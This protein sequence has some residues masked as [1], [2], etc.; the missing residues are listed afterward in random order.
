MFA[1]RS[2]KRHGGC[3]RPWGIARSLAPPRGHNSKAGP[4]SRSVPRSLG[5][6]ARITQPPRRS[7]SA[8]PVPPCTQ[9]RAGA[10]RPVRASR[11]R[12]PAPSSSLPGPA[13]E[14]P[15]EIPGRGPREFARRSLPPPEG[16]P[17]IFRRAVSPPR[18]VPPPSVKKSPARRVVGVRGRALSVVR[19]GRRTYR[20]QGRPPI[21]EP[22]PT[23]GAVDEPL[24]SCSTITKTFDVP[25][26]GLRYLSALDL[27][28]CG[29]VGRQL[30]F[31]VEVELHLALFAVE[32]ELNLALFAAEVRPEVAL[33]KREVRPG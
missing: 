30:L 28:T 8:P 10:V 11:V 31:A 5:G 9:R 1:P 14:S 7:D 4:P 12:V 16:P 15:T 29:R 32:V 33:F 26:G 18:R 25:G 3:K 2:S 27:S 21:V 23:W 17:P 22:G 20:G 24:L 19:S 13:R 6:L